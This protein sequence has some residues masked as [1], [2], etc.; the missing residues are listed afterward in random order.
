MA[1]V[2]RVSGRPIKQFME[3]DSASS[4]KIE[5]NMPKNRALNFSKIRIGWSGASFP[6]DIALIAKT[7]KTTEVP[8]KRNQSVE[9]KDFFGMAGNFRLVVLAVLPVWRRWRLLRRG[10]EVRVQKCWMGFRRAMA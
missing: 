2:I 5:E 6:K 4:E 3:K 7:R 1:T 9:V 10:S 8:E